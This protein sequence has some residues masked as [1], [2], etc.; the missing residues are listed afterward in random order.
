MIALG[1]IA[2]GAVFGLNFPSNSKCGNYIHTIL[3][4]LDAK[5]GPQSIKSDFA[6]FAFTQKS[7]NY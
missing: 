7:N 3:Y 4:F 1:I 2:L 6:F 5:N